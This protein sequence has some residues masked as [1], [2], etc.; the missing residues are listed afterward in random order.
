VPVYCN[1][2][3]KGLSASAGVHRFLWDVHFQSLAGTDGGEWF[4]ARKLGKESD[5]ELNQGRGKERAILVGTSHSS[6]N[7]R[8]L[9]EIGLRVGRPSFRDDIEGRDYNPP[10]R[11]QL[12][13]PGR[14]TRLVMCA[15]RW[16][17][18]MSPLR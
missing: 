5:T 18:I 16:L 13:A 12:V 11:F 14:R 8:G 4:D 3:P 9:T 10:R 2:P 15:R 6:T 17:L 7:F 1:R